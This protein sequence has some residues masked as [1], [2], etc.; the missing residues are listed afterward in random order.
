MSTTDKI[1]EEL[2]EFY[3]KKEEQDRKIIEEIKGKIKSIFNEEQAEFLCDM[4]VQVYTLSS[5]SDELHQ[6][7]IYM[8]SYV[9]A[10][11]ES[12]V[13]QK[14]V[15]TE[16]EFKPLVQEAYQ[17]AIDDVKQATEEAMKQR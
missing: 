5:D 10:F 3:A 9:D 8:T 13:V 11:Y 4:F 14:K 2:L 12:L 16:E 15:I 1:K 7:I 17:R 6:S